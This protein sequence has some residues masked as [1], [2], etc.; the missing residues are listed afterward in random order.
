MT[1]WLLIFLFLPWQ[2]QAVENLFCSEM[3]PQATS[4]RVDSTLQVMLQANQVLLR[5]HLLAV[6][7]P[8]NPHHYVWSVQE[9]SDLKNLFLATNGN[10][11]WLRAG[12]QLFILNSRQQVEYGGIYDVVAD[13]R[14]GSIL[15]LPDFSGLP[16]LREDPRT[17]ILRDTKFIEL[18]DDRAAVVVVKTLNELDRRR[19]RQ[20]ALRTTELQDRTHLVYLNHKKYLIGD[21]QSAYF[22]TIELA[23]SQFDG[24]FHLQLKEANGN[25]IGLRPRDQIYLLDRQQNIR[26]AVR[27]AEEYIS[28]KWNIDSLQELIGRNTQAIVIRSKL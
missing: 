23:V 5:G 28:A 6:M 13:S 24:F 3:F 20:N 11:H 15:N 8:G 14:V 25:G 2:S 19:L 26:M 1:R 9:D 7:V 22:G 16:I 21:T 12:D 17:P 10:V 18:F 4:Y 27:L